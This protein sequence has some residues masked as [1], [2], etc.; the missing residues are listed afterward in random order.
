M[1]RLVYNTL[2]PLCFLCLVP[3]F[4][5]RMKRRGGY[6]KDFGQRFGLYRPDVLQHLTQQQNSIWIQAVSVGEIFI[7]LE[8][9]DTYRKA[10]PDAHFVLS[11]NTS[12][13]Y[14]IGKKRVSSQDAIIYFPL[15][16]SL[17]IRKVFRIIRP[18]A[19]ILVECELWPNLI[20]LA[21]QKHIPTMLL[22]GR[23]S[24]HSFR[25][26][27]KLHW[28]T[29]A[30]LQDV[31]L[32]LVQ[33]RADAQRF[34]EL[35]AS[36][37]R[38]HITGSAKYDVIKR[39]VPGEQR[40]ESALK[41]MGWSP[42]TRILL[43]GSTWDGEETILAEIYVELKQTY[44]DLLLVLIPRHAERRNAVC[45][46]LDELHLKVLR[47]TDMTETST[48]ER[49]D[50][51]LVDTTGEMK[52]FFSC[53]D[54]IFIGKSLT[55]NGGQ[56]IIEPAFYGKTVIVGPNMQNFPGV[57]ID[58]LVAKAVV[59][60]QNRQELKQQFLHFMENPESGKA[61]GRNAAALV[62]KKSGSLKKSAACIA[63]HITLPTPGV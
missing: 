7:A 39:D 60:V 25:G 51:L 19:I 26:Y 10:C 44:P 28:F 61:L 11:T 30:L 29:R 37:E 54:I 8:F 38:L 3:R 62:E 22:N 23:M 4:L 17:I 32:L 1:L 33:T 20:N 47:R 2:F 9:I 53:A 6:K 36:P 56:N 41:Q 21:A 34:I 31:Q 15:D 43:G 35:G 50:V 49:P 27:R 14:A 55:Q 13:A 42:Q 45:A 48:H 58:F 12:T 5:M 24:D 18:A 40:T 46:V 57:M 63:Q 52:N 16:M 59:Q